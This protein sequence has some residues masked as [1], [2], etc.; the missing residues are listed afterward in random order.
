M[1]RFM[2]ENNDTKRDKNKLEYLEK[3]SFITNIIRIFLRF[4]SIYK[5]IT[6]KNVPQITSLRKHGKTL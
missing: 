1:K 2:G 5:R 3:K 6:G 4:I